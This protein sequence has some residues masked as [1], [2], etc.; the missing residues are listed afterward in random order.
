MKILPLECAPQLADVISEWI[1]S[2]WGVLDIHNHYKSISKGN[3]DK[4]DY[5]YSLVAISESGF[6]MGTVSILLNDM[7]IRPNLNPWLGCLFVHPEFRRKSVAN[8][9]FASCEVLAYEKN[10]PRL[11]LWTSKVHVM[12][13]KFG[14]KHVEQVFFENENVFVMEKY[15]GKT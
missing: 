1:E 3:F 15:F 11:F 5:P 8:A 10:I 13:E 6:A 14:W 4:D 7:D 2:E 9:L 12:A